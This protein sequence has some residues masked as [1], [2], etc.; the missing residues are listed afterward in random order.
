[1]KMLPGYAKSEGNTWLL[2]D[3]AIYV[4]KQYMEKFPHIFQLLNCMERLYVSDFNE[5]NNGGLEYLSEVRKW[6]DAQPYQKEAKKPVAMKH[7]SESAITEV[8]KAVEDAVRSTFGF[9]QI[10]SH[11]FN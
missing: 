1:M 10:F 9:N 5:N 7:L 3:K 8:K 6:L 2:S 4:V 11:F